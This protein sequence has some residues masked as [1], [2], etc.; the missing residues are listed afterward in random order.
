MPVRVLLV[1]DD[2][3]LRNAVRRALRLEGYEV[4]LAGDGGDALARLAGLRADVVVLD[5][6]MP[7]LDGVTVCRRLRER[8]D[9]TPVLMLTARDTVSD[10]VLG[11]DAGADDYLTKPFALE[12]LLARIRALVRR[13]YPE[14]EGCL[15]VDDLELN[16]RTRQV[17]RGERAME[18]TR[19]EFA[20]LE[21]LMRNPGT[22][23]TRE[24][25]WERVWGFEDAGE[26]NTLDVYVGYLRR[27]TEAG[28]E[29]RMIHTVRGVGFVLR[30][31]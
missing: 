13:S 29:T 19:T 12:E 8:G 4:E 2:E 21:L 15:R 24:S 23:L 20:L 30:G 3:A 18:L 10:R 6:L 22:V 27:K 16:P 9:R 17:A 25:I 26:S 28:G 11:L 31:A 5:V 14:H 7:V 1:D